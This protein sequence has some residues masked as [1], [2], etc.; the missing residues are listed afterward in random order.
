MAIPVKKYRIRQNQMVKGAYMGF[1]DDPQQGFCME[2]EAFTHTLELRPLDSCTEECVWGRLI[3]D[4]QL[5]DDVTLT[6]RFYASDEDFPMIENSSVITNSRD[7]LLYEQK[8]RYLWLWLEVIGNGNGMLREISVYT[9]GD[10]F[11]NTFPEVYRKHGSFFHRY[12]S[13]FSSIYLDFQQKIDKLPDE[14]TLKTAPPPVLSVMAGWLGIEASDTVLDENSLRELL[15]EA[16]YLLRYKGTKGAVERIA[17]L[18]LKKDVIIMERSAMESGSE[19]LYRETYN[20]LYGCRYSDFTILVQGEYD[21]AAKH[22]LHYL[23]DQFIPVKSHADLVFLTRGCRLDGFLYLDYNAAL[24]ESCEGILDHQVQ[25][26]AGGYL[27][28]KDS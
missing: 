21:E 4:I 14:I 24:H 19:D 15:R 1:Y 13:I 26:D 17:R 25:L 12:L 10:P 28:S 20:R 6:V 18:I 5:P 22:K 7:A 23:L 3:V 2:K 27:I 16:P 9:P 11:M 8:G